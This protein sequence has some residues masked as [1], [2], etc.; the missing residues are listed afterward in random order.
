M[1]KIIIWLLLSV[2]SSVFA[3]PSTFNVYTPVH[4]AADLCRTL[5]ALYDEEYNAT[6]IIS[7]RPGILGTMHNRALVADPKFSVACGGFSDLVLGS[8]QFPDQ[9]KIYD[10]LSVVVFMSE[11]PSRFSTGPSSKFNSLK[12]LIA[13]KKIITVG[14]NASV[15]RIVARNV[16]KNNTVVW[17]PYKS[18]NDAIPSLIDG[19]LDLYVEGGPFTQLVK[20]GII[21]SLGQINGISSTIDPDI[22][23]MYPDVAPMR[24]FLCVY[25][26]D[27]YDDDVAE[28]NRRLSLLMKRPEFIKTLATI[29]QKSFNLS[30]EKTREMVNTYRNMYTASASRELTK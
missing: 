20:S 12:D 11:A 27:N 26:T 29:N 16:L 4:A 14:Y 8:A 7:S 24:I 10:H 21:K 30:L 18:G 3:L 19:S 15:Y 2:S 1:K 6:T 17:V 22:T 13:D 5:F 28:L 25:T 9:K 23:S